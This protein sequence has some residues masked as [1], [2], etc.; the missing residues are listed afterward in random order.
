MSKKYAYCFQNTPVKHLEHHFT[1]RYGRTEDINL[2]LGKKGYRVEFCQTVKK[3]DEILESPLFRDAVKKATLIS[4]ILY[5]EFK[6][7]RVELFVDGEPVETDCREYGK[8]YTLCGTKLRSGF[9]LDWNNPAFL[10][11]LVSTVK[12]RKD[13]L[14]ASLSALVLAKSREYEAEKFMYLWMAMN[15]LYGHISQIAREWFDENDKNGERWIKRENGQLKF[16]SLFYGLEFQGI[17]ERTESKKMSDKLLFELERIIKTNPLTETNKESILNSLKSDD[18]CEI[19]IEGIHNVLRTCSTELKMDPYP[20]LL[21]WLPYQIRCRYFHSEKE[22]PLMSFA[23]ES[24]LPCL[25]IVNT[26]L[27]DFLDRELC[28]WF[29]TGQGSNEKKNLIFRIAGSC[30]FEKKGLFK[31]SSFNYE[32]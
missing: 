1:Y 18:R 2:Y 24:P 19:L 27:E 3:N 4:L 10:N 9:S 25:K 32:L 14:D 15:G 11:K 8:L 30:K 7:S 12:S 16:F 13:R 21:I 31:S 17:R 28:K 20:A 23:D 6:D 5:G 29:D 22:I 26:V